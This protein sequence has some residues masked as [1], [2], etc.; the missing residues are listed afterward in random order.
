MRRRLGSQCST[1]RRSPTSAWRHS[2]FSTKTTLEPPERGYNKRLSEGAAAADMAAEEGAAEAVAAFEAAPLEG[3]EAAPLEV[4]GA[5]A[6]A[7]AAAALAAAAA[8]AAVVARSGVGAAAAACRGE[9][10]PSARPAR[11]AITLTDAR[12]HAPG[13]TRFDPA[14]NLVCNASQMMRASGAR[15]AARWRRTYREALA[16]KHQRASLTTEPGQPETTPCVY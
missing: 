7:F 2:I 3:A 12:R 14:K 6:L 5:A 13:S 10:A 1:R 8:A 9:V 11:L 16:Q 15:R 4:A